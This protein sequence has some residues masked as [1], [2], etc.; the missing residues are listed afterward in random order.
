MGL[1]THVESL[2][3]LWMPYVNVLIGR[4]NPMTSALS[5]E[6]QIPSFKLYSS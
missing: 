4:T 5:V 2:A 6:G 1:N 3:K